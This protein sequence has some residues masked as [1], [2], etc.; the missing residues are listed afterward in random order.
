MSDQAQKTPLVDFLRAV[1]NDFTCEW[2]SH[3]GEDGRCIGHTRG[4]VGKHCHDAADE[5]E[6]LKALLNVSACGSHGEVAA[7]KGLCSWCDG[8]RKALEGNKP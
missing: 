7:A 1:P 2:E 6:Q 8:V 5:I 4:A 3:W